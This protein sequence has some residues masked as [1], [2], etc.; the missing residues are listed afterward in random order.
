V[1]NRWMGAVFF[2]TE[3]SVNLTFGL[4]T[5]HWNLYWIIIKKYS[6]N[7]DLVMTP[8][9]N[10]TACTAVALW[11][12]IHWMPADTTDIPNFSP[13]LQINSGS[14]PR[15]DEDGLI[16]NFPIAHCE[17]NDRN[18]V[19]GVNLRKIRKEWGQN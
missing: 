19:I 15:I 8:P 16:E 18:T 5:F 1:R 3:I 9:I 7:L 13:F 11:I 14:L 17:P 10:W 2:V 12:C 6:L 4:D